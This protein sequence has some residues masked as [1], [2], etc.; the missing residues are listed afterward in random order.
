[1]A[2]DGKVWHI[3]FY[4]FVVTAVYFITVS[5]EL[6]AHISVLSKHPPLSHLLSEPYAL[7]AGGRPGI[8]LLNFASILK[9]QGG[10]LLIVIGHV[11]ICLPFVLTVVAA[12]LHGFDRSLE[13]AAMDLG[14]SEMVTFKRITLPLIMPGILGGALLAFTVSFDNF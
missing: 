3:A 12:R 4:R 5:K 8:A 10:Y 9:L 6:G 7:R 1:M 14:A 2:G 11:L 13:E